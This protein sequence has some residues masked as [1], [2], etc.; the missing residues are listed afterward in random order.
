MKK[1]AIVFLIITG[2]FVGI[3]LFKI[4]KKEVVKEATENITSVKKTSP[5]KTKPFS[6]SL[7]VP[8]WNIPRVGNE[9][10][11]YD[12][13]IY[14][15]I[16][17]SA[18]GI[19]T[20]DSGYVGL[21][22]FTKLPFK[23]KKHLTVR[24]LDDDINTLILNDVEKQKDLI[25]EV[26]AIAQKNNFSGIV[27]DLEVFSIFNGRIKNQINDFVQLFYTQLKQERIEFFMTLYGDLFY[28]K[29]PYDTEF[30]GKNTDG[31]MIMAYDFHKS[32]GEPGPNFPFSGGSEYSYDFQ[33]MVEDFLRD[34]PAEK[35]TVVFG[36]YGYDWIVDEQK[37]PIKPAK[38][39]TLR[40]ITKKFIQSCQW[41]NCVVKRSDTA[42]ETEV[43]YVDEFDNF[44]IIWFEDE[45]SMKVK[46]DYIK[47]L[48]VGGV[49]LWAWGYFN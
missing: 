38:A 15:G 9:L 30:I 10:D 12:A 13:V 37:R 16:S 31:I 39:L 3:L 25:R 40:E 19:D 44:H 43:D 28:R 34:V 6:N 21:S 4:E 47:N 8:Y 29:R 24:M 33:R 11:S 14:F 23:Q 35:I 5:S 2:L 32:R 36:M 48:G 20:A 27:L 17:P 18:N 22:A 45:E 7:F 41:K 46:S 42:K 1:I 49:S 26:I